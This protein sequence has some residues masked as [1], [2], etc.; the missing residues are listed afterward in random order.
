MQGLVALHLAIRPWGTTAW[1]G[2]LLALKT[3]SPD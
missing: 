1:S 3:R 2:G